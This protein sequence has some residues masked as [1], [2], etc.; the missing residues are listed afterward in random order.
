MERKTDTVVIRFKEEGK[1]KAM[2][3]LTIDVDTYPRYNFLTIGP[4][5]YRIIQGKY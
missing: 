3:A 1:A 5:T 4:N 2:F